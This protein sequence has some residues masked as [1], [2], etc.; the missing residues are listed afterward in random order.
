VS[1]SLTAVLAAANRLGLKVEV[2]TYEGKPC[3]DVRAGMDWSATFWW[4]GTVTLS[5]LAH[6]T[7]SLLRQSSEAARVCQGLLDAGRSV[8]AHLE[9]V[10][11]V[12]S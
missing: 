1:P 11:E 2:G 12:A 7:A 3:V 9:V 4:G 8:V 10:R 5:V 6:D